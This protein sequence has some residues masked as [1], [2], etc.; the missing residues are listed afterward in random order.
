[1][2]SMRGFKPHLS[3]ATLAVALLLYTI[4][5]IRAGYIRDEATVTVR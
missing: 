2:F 3:L 1:M 4:L 5:V